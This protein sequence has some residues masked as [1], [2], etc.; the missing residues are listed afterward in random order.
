M[1][2]GYVRHSKA[3]NGF[4]PFTGLEQL[5]LAKEDL[6]W[7]DMQDPT[8]EEIQTLDR[9]FGFHHLALEDAVKPHQR[10]KIDSYGD[11]DFIVF[12]VLSYARESRSI[13]RLEV[14]LFV[15]RNYLVTVHKVALKEL[16]TAWQGWNA[17]QATQGD[18]G[19][20]FLLYTI[21]DTVVDRY[22]PMVEDLATEI[23]EME[24]RLF[25]AFDQTL[26]QQALSIRRCLLDIR[27]IVSSERDLVGLLTRSQQ[28]FFEP[29]LLFYFTDLYDHLI[30]V[31]DSVDLQRDL[32]AS[33][34]EGYLSVISNSLNQT[35][36]ILTAVSI[37]LM[38]SSLVTGIYGMNFAEMPGLQW[39]GGFPAIML[40]IAGLSGILLL[41]FRSRKWL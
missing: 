8:L 32:L 24:G 15:G 22:F 35:M 33:L 37:V 30:R 40:L 19:V 29:S 39:S 10:P 4:V 14:D 2:A 23:D 41:Y 28:P 7:L 27:R 13:E 16:D 36:R 1:I 38:A 11:F 9:R 26:L 18:Q 6:I 17:R 31:N 12:Y 25:Q 5:D 3:E 34:F 21:L 20:G